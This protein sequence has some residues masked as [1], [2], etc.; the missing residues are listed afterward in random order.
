MQKVSL[1]G[2]IVLSSVLPGA[3]LL[4]I[5]KGGWFAVYLGLF[6]LGCI[7]LFFLGLGVLLIIPVWIV[8]WTHTLVAV[9]KHNNLAS[10]G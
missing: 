8:S 2:A 1:L 4:L 10:V 6:I 3:G 7:L 5:Q 9:R